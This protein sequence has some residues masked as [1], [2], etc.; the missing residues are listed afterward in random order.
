VLA[1]SAADVGFWAQFAPR[2]VGPVPLV[3]K[4][5]SQPIAAREVAVALVELAVAAPVGLAPELAGPEKRE[6]P[7][8][9]RQLLRARGRRRA[10]IPVRLPGAVGRA[11]ASGGLLPAGP[12]PRGTQTFDQ[13][14]I[15]NDALSQ[16]DVAGGRRRIKRGRA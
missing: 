13:W 11:M 16:V 5:L 8:M 6:M 9:V 15:S 10:V 1:L 14:L 4:M 7:D 2:S 3:P 12:G